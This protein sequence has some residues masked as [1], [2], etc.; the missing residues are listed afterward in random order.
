MKIKIKLR[1]KNVEF[2]L[3]TFK[4]LILNSKVFKKRIANMS[5]A[6]F[7]KNLQVYGTLSKMVNE[8]IIE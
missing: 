2:K 8:K 5:M 7:F 3:G 1:L 6:I 4:A